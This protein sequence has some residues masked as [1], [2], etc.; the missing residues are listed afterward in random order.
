VTA[1][2]GMG[3]ILRHSGLRD[4]IK[5][6]ESEPRRASGVLSESEIG[7]VPPIP[8]NRLDELGEALVQLVSTLNPND[9]PPTYVIEPPLSDPPEFENEPEPTSESPDEPADGSDPQLAADELDQ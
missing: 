8:D 5:G 3:L 9:P 7:I 2:T 6:F 4:I 1:P